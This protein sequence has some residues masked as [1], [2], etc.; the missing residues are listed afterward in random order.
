MSLNTPPEAA[1]HPWLLP[2]GPWPR[3]H[4]GHAIFFQ[5]DWLLFFSSINEWPGRETCAVIQEKL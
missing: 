2:E 1:L 5:G 3:V 4:V